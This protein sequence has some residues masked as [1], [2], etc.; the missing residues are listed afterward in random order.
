MLLALLPSLA[1]PRPLPS[2]ALDARGPAG[3][4]D[5]PVKLS[6][7]PAGQ[8]NARKDE[9]AAAVKEV[10]DALELPVRIGLKTVDEGRDGIVPSG[11]SYSRHSEQ[12]TFNR[13][14][15]GGSG[16]E[17]Y[18][19]VCFAEPIAD[20]SSSWCIVSHM[21]NRTSHH[22][23][24]ALCVPGKAKDAV[25]KYAVKDDDD[26]IPEPDPIPCTDMPCDANGKALTEVT[27]SSSGGTFSETESETVR[28]ST[29][30]LTRKPPKAQEEQEAPKKAAKEQEAP[31]AD[32]GHWHPEQAN[33]AP[34]DEEVSRKKWEKEPRY[35]DKNKDK[36]IQDG[37]ED[38]AAAAKEEEEVSKFDDGSWHPD[39]Q[40]KVTLTLTLALTPTLTLTLTPTLTAWRRKFSASC[41]S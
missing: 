34:Y 27:Y 12:A 38:E 2:A 6:G 21:R 35:A 10:A 31:K 7:C 11:C 22:G 26:P 25:V 33:G 4:R 5:S 15:E 28:A 19:P 23:H 1:L 29:E 13:H 16:S 24:K 17:N 20:K 41:T 14:K 36:T 8:R 32:D 3:K 18:E 30:K 40:E 9:C 37:D 39:G